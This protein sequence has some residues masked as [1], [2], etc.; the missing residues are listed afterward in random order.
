[1]KDKQRFNLHLP[2]LLK[3]LAEVMPQMGAPLE[4]PAPRTPRPT[5]VAAMVG[6]G[7]RTLGGR[8]L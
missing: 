1:M 7:V 2:G 8:V 4:V 6:A 5:P 3:V